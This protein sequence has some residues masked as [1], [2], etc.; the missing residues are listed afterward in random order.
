MLPERKKEV[1]LKLK[2]KLDSILFKRKMK[3]AGFFLHPNEYQKFITIAIWDALEYYGLELDTF[4]KNVEN[5][6]DYEKELWVKSVTPL[7]FYTNWSGDFSV[8][9]TCANIANQVLYTELYQIAAYFFSK[10]G[11]YI[12]FGCGTATLSLGLKI[13]KWINGELFLLDVPNDVQNF[14]K[15]RINKHNLNK[16]VKYFDVLNY[17]EDIP[18]EGLL[19]IDVLEHIENSSEIFIE[20]IAPM[21][22]KEGYLIMRA[23]WRGQITHIDSAADNF[24]Y[25]GGRKYLSKHFKEVLR[26]GTNDIACVYKKV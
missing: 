11:T 25:G 17:K 24:Y 6:M 19:C 14:V 10:P 16:N 13:N 4:W 9:N 22:K 8:Y 5:W 18:V 21:I 1:F 15:Y 20:K 2:H 26:F 3:S 12:D 7:E 23:P